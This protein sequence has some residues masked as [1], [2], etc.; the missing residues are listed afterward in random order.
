MARDRSKEKQKEQDLIALG[1]C[2]YHKDKQAVIGLTM[3]EDCLSSRKEKKKELNANG[4]CRNHPLI[5]IVTGKTTCQQC[6]DDS[7]KRAKDRQNNGF[8]V[9]HPDR[10]LDKGIRHCNECMKKIN[11]R[12]IKLSYGITKEQYFIEC[13][14]RNYQCDLCNTKCFPAGSD[15]NRSDLYHIDHD[16]KTKKVRGFL[17]M[18]CNILIGHFNENVDRVQILAKNLFSYLRN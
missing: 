17:C 6:I 7:F 8:C 1:K 3:C 2:R 15:K 12:R 16:H 10:L 9:N 13:E 5:D 4:K 18:P 11:W 14:K